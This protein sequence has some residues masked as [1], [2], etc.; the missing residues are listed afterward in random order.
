M[1][2]I[3]IHLIHIFDTS[4]FDKDPATSKF[5]LYAN[6]DQL[7]LIAQYKAK[8]KIIILPVV[9]SGPANLTFGG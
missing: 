7:S 5:E 9:G 6:A 8:G 3:K 2:H 4:G 1:L